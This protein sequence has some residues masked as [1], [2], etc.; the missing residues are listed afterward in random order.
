MDFAVKA[1]KQFQKVA[2][3]DPFTPE[4]HEQSD[5]R[6]DQAESLSFHAK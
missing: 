1:K 5:Q 6:R 3:H 4:S 2:R